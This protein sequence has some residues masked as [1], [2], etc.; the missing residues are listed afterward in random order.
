MITIRDGRASDAQALS[1]GFAEMGWDRP[2]ERFHAYL[3]DA[4]VRMLVAVN[5]EQPI[6]HAQVRHHADGASEI[7]D[8]NV[9]APWRRRGAASA[10]LGRA[11][12]LSL[13][14]VRLGVGVTADYGPALALYLARGYRPDGLGLSQAGRPVAYGE[15]VTVD[16]GLVLTLVKEPA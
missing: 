4:T 2:P 11:E 9:L 5:G 3:S 12:A 13:R 15:V 16:D 8:L 6:G 1:E 7:F 10:L 14:S